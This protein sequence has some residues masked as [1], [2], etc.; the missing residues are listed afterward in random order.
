MCAYVEIS[1]CWS[2]LPQILRQ[3]ETFIQSPQFFHDISSN[4][5]DV[6]F[7]FV[8]H[9]AHQSQLKSTFLRNL[10]LNI[11]ASNFQYSKDRK[12]QILGVGKVNRDFINILAQLCNRQQCDCRGILSWPTFCETHRML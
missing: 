9:S 1:K 5:W 12:A 8:F 4:L 11:I 3:H 6:S 7:F 10:W 2:L